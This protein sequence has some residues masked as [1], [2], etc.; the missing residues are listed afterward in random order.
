LAREPTCQQTE[1]HSKYREDGEEDEYPEEIGR[2]IF[3]QL[4]VAQRYH[5][6]RDDH[7][8]LSTVPVLKRKTRLNKADQSID[9]FRLHLADVLYVISEKVKQGLS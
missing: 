2:L 3:S 9:V 7:A 8:G 6:W 5:R 4:L 1:S